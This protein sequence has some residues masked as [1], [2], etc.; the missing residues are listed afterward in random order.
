MGDLLLIIIILAV[1]WYWWDTQQ[2]NETALLVCRQK[3][4]AANLQLL[5]ATVT[6]ERSW[7]RRGKGGAVQICRLYSFEFDSGAPS[8]FIYSQPVPTSEFGQREQGYVV[9]IGKQVVETHLPHE[10]S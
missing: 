5:D 2:C 4:A 10:G 6:R 7:L 3:C 9:L 8:G 1:I